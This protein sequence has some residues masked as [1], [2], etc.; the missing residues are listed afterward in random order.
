MIL[1]KIQFNLINRQNDNYSKIY[2]LF[3]ICNGLD[4]LGF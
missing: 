1:N 2:K 4:N 3:I